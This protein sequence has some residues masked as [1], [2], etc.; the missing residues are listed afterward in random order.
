VEPS[1]GLRWNSSIAS[2]TK[3]G[4]RPEADYAGLEVEPHSS[5]DML[6]VFPPAR[7]PPTPRPGCAPATSNGTRS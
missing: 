2:A 7:C 3:P 5:Q 6:A 4:S 1:A